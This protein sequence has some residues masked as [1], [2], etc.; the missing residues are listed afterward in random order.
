MAARTVITIGIFDGVHVGHQALIAR[1]HAL[2][3]QRGL[4]AVA[5]TFDPLPAQ[6]LR[7]AAG[8]ARLTDIDERAALLRQAGA[9][10][11]L[12][13]EPTRQFLDLSAAGFVQMLAAEHAPAAVV[14]GPDFR[15]GHGRR[16]DIAMLAQA[17]HDLGFEAV[18]VPK[19][20]VRLSDLTVV[21]VSSSLV[22]WLTAQ[23]RTLDAAATLGRPLQLTATVVEGE[24]RG[25]TLGFPTAN[26]DPAALVGRALPADGVYA[27]QAQ[28]PGGAVHAAAISIGVKPTLP[29]A[30]RGRTVEAH[31]LDF[32]GD[33][34]GRRVTLRFGRWLREQ[35]VFPGLESLRAQMARDLAYTRRMHERGLLLTPAEPAPA[36]LPTGHQ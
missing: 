3:R 34:Y 20:Q 29:G 25:R 14:E 18:V 36:G 23:G 5:I 28:W 22:R 27:G 1:A 30:A 12:V 24:K 4:T 35:R 16:G 9:D 10:A 17:G 26:L 33:L 31:L 13:I 6:V 2:A 19:V 7:P 32:A 15:F 11:V 21:S 8:L